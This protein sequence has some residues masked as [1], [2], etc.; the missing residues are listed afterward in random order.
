MDETTL[1]VPSVIVPSVLGHATQAC[2]VS[3]AD[4]NE[5]SHAGIFRL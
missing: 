4:T 2:G 3:G 5:T 1:C